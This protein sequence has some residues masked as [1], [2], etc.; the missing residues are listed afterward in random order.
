VPHGCRQR[1]HQLCLVGTNA[2]QR[3]GEHHDQKH[4]DAGLHLGQAANEVLLET[5]HPV[6]A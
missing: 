5:Q 3:H 4:G 1:A 2:A 6:D